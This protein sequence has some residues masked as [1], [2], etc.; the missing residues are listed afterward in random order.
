MQTASALSRLKD[1]TLLQTDSFIDDAWVGSE[2]R[3][4][5]TDPATGVPLASVANLSEEAA[6]QAIDA[7]ARAWPSWRAKT[8]RERSSILMKWFYLLHENIDDL[9]CLMTAEQGKPLSEARGEVIYGAGFF[10]WF[11]EEGRRI[12]GETIPSTDPDKRFLVIKQAIG[13][14]AAITPWNFPI[15]MIARKVAPALAA[16]C[17]MV[18][19]PAEQT[20]LCALALAVLGQRAGLPAG[21]FNVVTAD[22]PQSAAMG[23]VLCRSEQIRHLSFTG[24]T[25]VGRL[26][27]SQCAP[28]LKKLSLELG[29][30]A[31]FI[32]FDDADLDSA[33][34]GAM[35]SKFR[36]AG[37]TC[38]CANRMYV[39]AGIF[40]TFVALLA[41]RARTLRVG[42]GF[43]DGVQ[44]G[45]LINDEAIDKVQCHVNDALAHGAKL[46]TGGSTINHRFFE[47]TV[48]APATQQM[49]CAKEEIFGPVAPVF[50]FDTESEVIEQ[51]N[52]T[53][54][55]LASY[56]YTRNMGRAIRVGEALEYGM[57]GINT[58]LISAVEAPFGGI[59]QSGFGR[60][61]SRHG[62]DDY[63]EIKYLC[64]AGIQS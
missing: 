63:V 10:E 43:D 12:Y 61:G 33:V 39:Q 42:N 55:G 31:P 23:Q 59:K 26:L 58:G 36:N 38:V 54:F 14:C 21:V 18:L 27:M 22:G 44:L 30:N 8:A 15:A 29:G 45:P 46:H 2:H 32:V 35:V 11:A 20:P 25:E 16:G 37:Q 64:L 13:V 49:R 52:A 56:V 9:A 34:E 50:K 19:K 7:A 60:E 24:S 62:I 28:T 6:Q 47:P 40:D 41:T 1:I 53:E 5:V 51:A 57:V 48:L 4:E 3:F 17:T